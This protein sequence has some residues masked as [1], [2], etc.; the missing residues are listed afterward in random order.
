MI[1]VERSFVP[2]GQWLSVPDVILLPDG[3]RQPTPGELVEALE[4]KFAAGSSDGYAHDA[5]AE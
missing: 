5:A 4:I 1:S 2:Y 3:E